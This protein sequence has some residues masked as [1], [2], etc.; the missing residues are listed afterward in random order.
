[1]AINFLQSTN[2]SDDAKLQFGNSTDFEIYHDSSTNQNKITSLLGRQLL[3]NTASFVVN[4]AADT[5]N[6]IIATDG[7][8]VSLY[9]AGNLKLATTSVGSTITGGLTTTASSSLAGANMSAGI[10]MGTNAITG[11]ANPSSAQDAATKAYVDGALPTVNNATITFS[12]GTGLTGGGTITL[13]QSSN[14]TVTFNNSITNNNQLTNGAGYTTNTGTTTASNTQTFTN[15][16]GNISQWTNDSGYLTSAGSM[17]SWT[18]TADSGGSETI[19]NGES[20]DIAGGTNITTSRSGATVTISTSATTNTGTVTS[21]A[22]GT[23]LSGGTI[24]GSGTISV[25]NTVVLTNNTQ[26]ISGGKT[27]SDVL[28]ATSD[29]DM[30]SGG[31]ILLSAT[32]GIQIDG[33]PGVGKFLKSVA[34]GMEWTTI[35]QNS[36]TVTS[37]ATSSPITGGTIT[38]SGTIG[39]DS[40]AVTSLSNLATTGTVTT[41]TWNSNTRLDKTSTTDNDYQG[42][43]VY[44]GGTTV[45][46]GKIYVYS[47]GDWISADADAESTSKGL[48]AMSVANGN[49]GTVGMLTRGMFTLS[50]DPGNDGDILYISTTTGNLTTEPPSGS[51]KVVRIVGTLLD[52]TNGQMFFHPDNT[53]ITLS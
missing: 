39:F 17:S 52:S 49:S 30:E 50:Y 12:A 9:C 10:A 53:Y 51:Q 48:L 28:T 1:M 14:E 3:I 41:G 29:I 25:D 37:V 40:S 22:T 47:G 23:G 24:T 35:T 33:D 45:V 44:L 34:S 26:T 32:G 11:M 2:F 43:L 16:S 13:N 27:F 38:G 42:E 18:L 46:K 36:G 6:M 7:G 15:K 8:A 19:T 4:N 21:V 5:Q 31:D 20:V